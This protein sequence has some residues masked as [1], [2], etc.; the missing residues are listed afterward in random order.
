MNFLENIFYRLR[1]AGPRPVLQEARDGQLSAAAASHLLAS[2]E[3]ARVFLRQAGLRKGDRTVLLAPN[4]IRWAAL[5]LAMMAEGLI[6]VP[7]Y[8]RQ[9]PAELVAMMKDAAP[10]LICCGDSSLR[11]SVSQLWPGSPPLALFDEIFADSGEAVSASAKDV[12]ADPLALADKDPVTIIYTSGTS[13]EAKG[14][15]LTVRNLNHML[16][17]TTARLD[18]LME[19][20]PEPDRVFHYLPFCFAGSWI[21]LLSCLSRNS[22]LTL[23][24]DL[25]KLAEEMRLAAPNYFLNVPALLERIR[26]A[27]ESQVRK[28]GG[29]IPPLFEKAKSAWLR[30]Q[31][32]EAASLD[33][34]WLALGKN[35]IFPPIRRGLGLNL[36]TLICGSAPL[37]KETQLFFHMLGMPVL[38]VYGLTET[39]AICTMDDPR[40]IEPGCVGPSIEGIEMRLAE[41]GEILVRGPNVFSGYWNKPQATAEVLR[42]GWFHTGDQGEMN[43]SGSWTISGRIKNLI[44]LSSGHNIAPE[45]IEERLLQM[46][47][48]AQQ[49]ALIGNGRSFLAAIVTGSVAQAQAESTLEKLNAELPHYKRI[50]AFHI[51]PEPFSIENG[52]LTANGKFKREAIAQRFHDAIEELYC[53]VSA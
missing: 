29:P 22:I 27:I 28:R 49:V 36:K 30:S 19:S 51:S 24:M 21:L 10:A 31:R 50:R 15:L 5:D 1:Q 32:G 37:A 41:N 34:L 23:S 38:Q 48:G 6:V 7:L 20:A 18:L 45:P 46:L 3:T 12:Q 35:V 4:G 53:K 44:I 2:V 33:F 52:L 8:A 9:S 39:T 47:P 43:S 17:C 25:S 42:G 26:A 14:V 11:D 13:G 40:H 16:R